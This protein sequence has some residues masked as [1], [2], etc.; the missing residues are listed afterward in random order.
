MKNKA[1]T[2]LISLMIA[3][4][5]L[6]SAGCTNKNEQYAENLRDITIEVSIDSK[7][8]INS[9]YKWEYGIVDGKYILLI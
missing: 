1:K 3:G 7:K 9:V 5:I 8:T 6:S 4:T 2:S